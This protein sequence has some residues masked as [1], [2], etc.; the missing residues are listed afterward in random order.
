MNPYSDELGLHSITNSV[1]DDTII[2]DLETARSKMEKRS[3]EAIR[4]YCNLYT[5]PGFNSDTIKDSYV[6]RHYLIRFIEQYF[7]LLED[8]DNIVIPKIP[9]SEAMTISDL[10]Q[11]KLELVKT[12]YP[13]SYVLDTDIPKRPRFRKVTLN[14]FTKVNRLLDLRYNRK[15]ANKY[16]EPDSKPVSRTF[17]SGMRLF[18]EALNNA[19][20]GVCS[21]LPAIMIDK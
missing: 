5:V 21:D 13:V 9:G 17:T 14:F 1:I 10:V 20:V 11:A 15:E 12:I 2:E 4:K 16:L 7:E 6:F 18:P 3:Y 8:Q 19:F